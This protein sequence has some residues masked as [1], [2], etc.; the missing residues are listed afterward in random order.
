MSRTERFSPNVISCILKETSSR[1]SEREGLRYNQ[2]VL[3][4]LQDLTRL[5]RPELERIAEEVSGA[6]SSDFFSV[7][8]QLFLA[9]TFLAAACIPLSALWLLA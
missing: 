3:D 6:K 2:D 5:P 7:R 1:A 4:A 9:G 8:Q